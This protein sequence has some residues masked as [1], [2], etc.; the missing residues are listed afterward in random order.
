MDELRLKAQELS[1]RYEVIQSRQQQLSTLP[2]QIATLQA[3][4]DALRV[5]QPDPPSH[6]DLALPYDA[7]ISLLNSR[8]TE[9]ATLD[10][11]IEALQATSSRQNRELQRLEDELRPLEAKKDVTV[12]AAKEARKRKEEGG[13]MDEMEEMGRWYRGSEKV[14]KSVVETG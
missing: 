6:P 12:K 1:Q 8:E 9:L 3:D 13:G 7:T 2:E 14:L 11:Q 4:I 5:L 10:A